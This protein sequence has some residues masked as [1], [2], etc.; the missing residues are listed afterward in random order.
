MEA[1]LSSKA[2]STDLSSVSTDCTTYAS[3]GLQASDSA[4][5]RLIMQHFSL[6]FRPHKL[7]AYRWVPGIRTDYNNALTHY[8]A[9]ATD[10]D[11]AVIAS[12]AG[13]YTS[14]TADLQ[15][16]SAALDSDDAALSETTADVNAAG[17]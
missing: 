15:A 10:L 6:M 12:N 1:A 16:G 5:L 17:S 7:T 11:N 14:A 3:G 2:I 4:T 8:N 9:A 13:D